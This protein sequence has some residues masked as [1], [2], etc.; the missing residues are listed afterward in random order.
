[1]FEK[2]YYRIN[3]VGIGPVNASKEVEVIASRVFPK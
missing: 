1:M 2:R 3:S